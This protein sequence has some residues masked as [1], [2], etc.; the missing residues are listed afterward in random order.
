MGFYSPERIVD[1]SGGLFYNLKD[2]GTIFDRTTRHLVSSTRFALIFA[3]AYRRFPDH[4]QR[5]SWKDTCI[6]A[7]KFLKQGHW[8]CN[9]Y[10][11]VVQWDSGKR[12]GVVDESERCYGYA[13]VILATANCIL[14]RIEEKQAHT[15]LA[16]AFDILEARFWEERQQLYADTYIRN[17]SELLRYRGRTRTCT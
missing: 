14:A 1:P 17:S 7:L 2:D 13:F 12:V 9:A 15:L 11:W 3:Q 4:P 6:H 10:R 8:D 5:S 16:E